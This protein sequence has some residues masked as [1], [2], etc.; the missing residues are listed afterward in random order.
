ME[1]NGAVAVFVHL[2]ELVVHLFFVYV[3]SQPSQEE[4]QGPSSDVAGVVAVVH[5]EDLLQFLDLLHLVGVELLGVL[6]G[7]FGAG[8]AGLVGGLAGAPLLHLTSMEH[9]DLLLRVGTI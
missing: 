5:L 2:L 8:E 7:L 4:L 3:V 6:T 1:V 9:Y